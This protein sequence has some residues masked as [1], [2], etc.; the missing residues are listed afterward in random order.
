MMKGMKR[1]R[2]RATRPPVDE[3]VEPPT[4]RLYRPRPKASEVRDVLRLLR[5]QGVDEEMSLMFVCPRKISS[6]VFVPLS[7]CPR[8]NGGAAQLVADA[9]DEP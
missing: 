9:E 1:M 8:K 4:S 2:L 6:L 3:S 5:H 7:C